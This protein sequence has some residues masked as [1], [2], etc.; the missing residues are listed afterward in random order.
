MIG[1]YSASSYSQTEN[2]SYQ[3]D[4]N[5]IS[6]SVT[7]SN[8]TNYSYD[9]LGRMN[10]ETS[11]TA[12]SGDQAQNVYTFDDYNNRTGLTY[13]NYVSSS[14]NTQTNY[15][16]DS[17]NRLQTQ[18]VISENDESKTDYR[19][20]YDNAGNLLNKQQLQSGNPVTVESF[21]YD[22]LNETSSIT[23]GSVATSFKYDANDQR[24]S[25]TSG[26]TTTESLWDGGSIV[27][28]FATT[29]ST[30]TY[31]QYMADNMG[32][33]VNG[34]TAYTNLINGQGDAIATA[35]SSTNAISSYSFD[36]YGNK[37]S[38]STTATPFSYRN[39]Y[40]DSETGLYYLN[41]R[42]YDPSAGSFTQEDTYW[43]SVKSPASLNLYGYCEG[44]PVMAS[45]PS[46][47]SAYPGSYIRRGSTGSY[48]SQVQSQLNATIGAGL[49]VDGDFGPKTE[50]AVKSFQSSRGLSVDGIVGPLTWGALFGSSSSGGSTSSS[51]VGIVPQDELPQGT[52]TPGWNNINPAIKNIATSDSSVVGFS[53]DS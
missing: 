35:N 28:D 8:Y 16:Y 26:S 6:K 49:A 9:N 23:N 45:D 44:N 32:A 43:G 31:N 15:T 50:A 14:E 42:Y 10:A 3:L 39:Q 18:G 12:T 22:A 25:K 47:H 51:G 29:G 37:T 40:S 17:A 1:T 34:G 24:I 5:L 27:A 20:N 4:G 13:T 2:Y 48:V 38:G 41:A 7:G 52:P 33:I 19:Y 21:V 46:G 53:Y 30:T 11:G 36:A